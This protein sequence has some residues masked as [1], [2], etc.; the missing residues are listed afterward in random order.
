MLL[1]P[2][3]RLGPYELLAPLGAGGM[4]EVYRARDTR[5]GRNVAVKVPQQRLAASDDLRARFRSC[6]RGSEGTRLCS[7]CQD[8]TFGYL[9]GIGVRGPRTPERRAP[10][11]VG[12]RRVLQPSH[13]PLC[14]G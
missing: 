9:R 10:N 3:T 6:R 14:A 13:N 5:L 8:S 2:G 1:T 12:T 11:V 4:G 7:Q